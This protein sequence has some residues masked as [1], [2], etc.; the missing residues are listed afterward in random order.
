[1]S[2]SAITLA[3]TSTQLEDGASN[4]DQNAIDNQTPPSPP[5]TDPQLQNHQPFQLP[6]TQTHVIPQIQDFG[7]LFSLMQ[8][9][10]QGQN[11]MYQTQ[12]ES[13]QRQQTEQLNQQKLQMETIRSQ[14]RTINELKHE[15]ERAKDTKSNEHANRPERPTINAGLSDNQWLVVVSGLVGK[16]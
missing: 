5:P 12:M 14:N 4:I 6:T 1:M 10:I 9:Q 2:H 3:D 16:I 13:L 7:A 8:Q 11:I 15:L